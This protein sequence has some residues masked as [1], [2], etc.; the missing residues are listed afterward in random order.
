MVRAV[1]G[2]DEEELS[3]LGGVDHGIVF[4]SLSSAIIFSGW[5]FFS[6]VSSSVIVRFKLRRLL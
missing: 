3:V 5:S 1:G 4:E 2:L 6:D